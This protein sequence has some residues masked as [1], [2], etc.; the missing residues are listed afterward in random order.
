MTGFT[1]SLSTT[2]PA[3]GRRATGSVSRFRRSCRQWL[4][5]DG[6][7]CL[8]PFTHIAG[9]AGGRGGQARPSAGRPS[10]PIM[11]TARRSSPIAGRSSPPNGLTWD[12]R[13]SRNFLI[14]VE[15]VRGSKRSATSTT[16]VTR[17]WHWS[18]IIKSI[19]GAGCPFMKTESRGM[20]SRRGKIVGRPIRN[21][22]PAFPFRG[23][24][25]PPRP[26]E[27]R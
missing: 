10:G 27:A 16:S 5:R 23:R 22:P 15:S 18:S 25:V 17:S 20:T 1:A 7:H 19:C 21:T 12:G 2:R 26:G 8:R 6:G 11:G 3:P 4:L 14:Y 24:R 13:A 9:D